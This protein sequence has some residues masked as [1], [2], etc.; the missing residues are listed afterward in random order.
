MNLKLQLITAIIVTYT[1]LATVWLC[2]TNL[3]IQQ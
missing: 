2:Y 1:L 3:H